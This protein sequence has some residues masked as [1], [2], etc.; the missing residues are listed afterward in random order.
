MKEHLS[1]FKTTLFG[2][3]PVSEASFA[4]LEEIIQFRELKRDEVLLQEGEVARNVHFL[5]KGAMIAFF[6]DETGS[7]YN[8]NIFLENQFAGSTV[9][10]LLGVPSQFTLQAIEDS[11]IITINYKKYKA[12]IYAHEDLK[13]FYIAYLE[14]NW[15]IDKEQR[16]IS[17]VMENATTRYLKLLKAH[18]SI[19]Q[20]IPL[21]HIASHLGITPT[22][23]SR[24]RKELKEK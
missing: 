1:S 20:R 17:I 11:T 10:A 19:D 18:P 9:S 15:I 14:R 6:S 13:N 5:C 2:Y 3:Y 7:T 4:L 24:I 12:L 16:E 8:K 23:L 22:Q 21:Q